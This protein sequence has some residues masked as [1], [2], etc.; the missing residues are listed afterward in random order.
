MSSSTTSLP[1]EIS[2]FKIS[3]GR[4][5]VEEAV[6]ALAAIIKLYDTIL[7]S[8]SQIRSLALVEEKEG[9]RLAMEGSEAYFHATRS[10]SLYPLR[11][12][13]LICRCFNLA[14]IH[15]I[16]PSP[17][18]SSAVQLLSRAIDLV[19]QAQTSLFDSHAELQETIVPL[20]PSSVQDLSTNI[21]TLDLAAK[22]ALFAERVTKPV[23]F[24]TAFNYIDLPMDE[25]LVLAGKEK[26]KQ[27]EGSI[28]KAETVVAEVAKRAVGGRE[29][30]RETT[31]AV[32]MEKGEEGKPKGWLGGWFGRK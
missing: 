7:Q 20:S 23:F 4:A 14:R 32:E 5:K 25:L 6:K 18:Y 9:V 19:Q 21:K 22:R 8:M 15:C 27:E 3:G 29:K 16:H 17:S 2:S 26:P 24:D 1:S 13:K 12:N 10:A 31:P 11:P 30:T 28:E